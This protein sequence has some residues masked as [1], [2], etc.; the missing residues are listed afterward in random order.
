MQVGN[1][2]L[3]EGASI[4]NLTIPSGTSFPANGNLGELFILLPSKVL[5][6]HNG[7]EWAI[8]RSW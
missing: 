8:I 4:K 2:E 1:L 3:T 7:E 6:I 5:H